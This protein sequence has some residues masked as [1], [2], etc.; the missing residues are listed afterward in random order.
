M[1]PTFVIGLREGLEAALI[2]SIV[3]T[4]LKR[5]GESLKAM[6]W[7][8]IAAILISIAV[9]VTL[10]LVAQ[11]LP[12]R[13]QEML[14][15]VI[16]AVAVIFVTTM[17]LWM[18][19]HARSMKTD[20]EQEADAA[21]AKGKSSRAGGGGRAMA[22]MAFLAV[23][24]EG[25]ES[26][27]F[28]LAT[29]Q[30]SSSVGPA[31]LGS[32]LG[33]VLAALIGWGLYTGGVRMNLGRFFKITGP[34]LVFVAAGLVVSCLRTAHEATW[35]Q[36]GQQRTVDL[37]WLAQPGTIRSALITGVLGIPADPR[38]IEVIGYF[39]FLLPMLAVLLWPARWT[40][41]PALAPRVSFGFA[42]GLALVAI[43]MAAFVRLPAAEVPASRVTTA[44]GSELSFEQTDDAH[45]KLTVG[46]QGGSE[47]SGSSGGQRGSGDASGTTSY[48][49]GPD[50]VSTSSGSTAFRTWKTSRE[51]DLGAAKKQRLT[52]DQLLE[53][54]GGRLPVGVNAQR[55]PG[56]FTAELAAGANASVTTYDGGIVDAQVAPNTI[57]KLSGGGLETQK[58]ITLTGGAAGLD[59]EAAQATK[60]GITGAKL[61]AKELMLYKV[62]LPV[63]LVLAALY[64]GYVGYSQRRQ[65][66]R[67][68]AT[69]E[70]STRNGS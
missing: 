35:I 1:L 6:W 30:A 63:V 27:V 4:F 67:S 47:G 41:G 45:A 58:V 29:F 33:F 2:V 38:V 32:V 15:T 34:F 23:L 54:N 11:A 14:E 61:Q 68:T 60:D 19:D 37:S 65:L 26:A 25:F 66:A 18:R 8:V 44:D 3:A 31:A 69:A 22:L 64:A 24:K 56:P 53:L 52:I 57:V 42:A 50:D 17:I 12:Q 70:P 62:W 20:L 40:P 5:R 51:P 55:N 9:G 46:G 36:I 43:G 10:E 21:L 59:P 28:L 39:L 7:G 48:E 49:F 16:G 13:E